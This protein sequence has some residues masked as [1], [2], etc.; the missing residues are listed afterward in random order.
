MEK[1]CHTCEYK[2]QETTRRPCSICEKFS[3]W[4]GSCSA[5]KHRTPEG[6]KFCEHEEDDPDDG[7]NCCG[8][9]FELKEE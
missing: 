1:N 8:D 6:P 4:T 2:G 9:K 3:M 5:C 7:F